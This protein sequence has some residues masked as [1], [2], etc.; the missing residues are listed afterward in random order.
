MWIVQLGSQQVIQARDDGHL[1]Q[2]GDK[3]RERRQSGRDRGWNMEGEEEGGDKGDS[4]MCSYPRAES[5][6]R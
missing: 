5:W 3:W 1:N 2:D 6:L 4:S